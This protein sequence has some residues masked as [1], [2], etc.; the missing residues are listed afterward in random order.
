MDLHLTFKT[1]WI[2]VGLT[3]FF[4]VRKRVSQR[5]QFFVMT[6]K[7]FLIFLEKYF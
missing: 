5:I 2:L 6:M 7:T 1:K 4:R 3:E